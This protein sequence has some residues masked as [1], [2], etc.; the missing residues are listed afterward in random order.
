MVDRRS[1]DVLAVHAGTVVLAM[2][3]IGQLYSDS[4]Y[5]TDVASDAYALAL[6]AGATLIDME[7]VQFE[8]VVTCRRLPRHGNADSHV[9]RW[10]AASQCQG[11][12]LHV[13]L[14]EAQ[15]GEE[16]RKSANVAVHPAGD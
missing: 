1:S 12:T 11:R 15:G 3:G 16:D 4:T 5:P 9:G 2:G 13:S 14:Q 8:P 10:S 7:F 6:E